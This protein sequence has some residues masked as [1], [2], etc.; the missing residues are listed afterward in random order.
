MSGADRQAIEAEVGRLTAEI[1]AGRPDGPT[2]DRVEFRREQGTWLL[3]VVIDH[4]GGVTLDHCTW[5]A[6][7]LGQ[8]LDRVDP[9]PCSYRLEVSSPGLE[10][11]LER[12]A[13]FVRHVGKKATLH[14]YRAIEGGKSVTGRLAGL[15]DEGAIVMDLED[16]RRVKFDRRDVCRAHLAID[17]SGGGSKDAGSGPRKKKESS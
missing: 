8:V 9:I 14:F 5:V 7:E 10:R 11:P 12:D 2:L 3:R 6:E 13:D 16:R 1:L 4:P 15:D 17:W